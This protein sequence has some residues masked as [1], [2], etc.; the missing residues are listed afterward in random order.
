[1]VAAA[2]TGQNKP[3]YASFGHSMVVD[4]WGAVV[5]QCSEAEDMCFAEI[6]LDYLDEVRLRQPLMD[7]RR[8]DLY[9][10]RFQ[11]SSWL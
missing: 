5:A 2:Q 6:N 10:L 11:H 3:D 7:L 8:R 1:M 9:E 4:P